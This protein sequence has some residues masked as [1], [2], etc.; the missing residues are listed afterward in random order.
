MMISVATIFTGPARSLE[1]AVTVVAL[2][3]LVP[4]HNVYLFRHPVF[5]PRR[6]L[7]LCGRDSYP[8]QPYKPS[9]SSLDCLASLYDPGHPH[10]CP[11][12]G[13]G[14]NTAK[15]IIRSGFGNRPV[16]RGKIVSTPAN[17][18]IFSCLSGALVFPRIPLGFDN[19][20]ATN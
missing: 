7:I 6:V 8:A 12:Q 19:H 11:R 2:T 1:S 5:K 17:P 13:Q 3:T 18:D 15:I 9:A 4:K 20:P 10:K 14:L 16:L